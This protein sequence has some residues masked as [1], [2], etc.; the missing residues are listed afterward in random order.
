MASLLFINGRIFTAAG[1]DDGQPFQEAM[2]VVGDSIQHVGY[3]HDEVI[4]LAQS[5]GVKQ[6]DLD[7][8]IVAPGFIDSH[9]HIMDYSLSQHA[10]DLFPLKSLEEIRQSI[11]AY[12]HRNTQEPRIVCQGWI[13]SGSNDS[14]RAGL[15]DDLDPRPI[16]IGSKDMH[17][18]WC[19]TAALEELGAMKLPD[20]PGGKIHRDSDGKPTGLLSESAYLCLVWPFVVR[21]ASQ[22]AKVKAMENWAATYAAAGY[23]GVIDMAMG[24]DSWEALKVV[25]ERAGKMFPLHIAAHWLIPY[26]DDPSVVSREVDKVIAMRHEYHPS[27]SPDFCILGIKLLGD[28]VVDSCTAALNAPYTGMETLVNPIWPTD[29][30]RAVIQ[31]AD[32]AGLQ[33]AV[34]AIGDG[35]VTQALDAF[36]LA[37]PGARHRVEH[38]ELTSLEDAQRLGKLGITASVQPAHSD[39]V[40]FREWPQLI[41][42]DRC[43]RAFAYRDF[44][45][46][47]APMAFGTDAPTATHLPLHFLYSATTRRST[48]EPASR[49]MVN[50]QFAVSIASAVTAATRNAA[51]SRFAESWTGT[52]KPGMRAD[53]VVLDMD[54]KPQSLLQGKVC[55]TWAGGRKV[56]DMELKG[57]CAKSYD[58]R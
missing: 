23:T 35:A 24:E 57:D 3:R 37:T 44:L 50:S 32:A 39:P 27:K 8:K 10:L 47:G 49:E 28:G 15:L 45:E 55:Q 12:A 17:S 20:P 42:K 53:F 51:Y 58:V 7:N 40:T 19:N 38:L 43:G 13:Q 48:I 41:G 11:R 1:E 14:I 30:F 21:A 46:A 52:L 9:M 2:L 25:R 31:K 22:D 4:R 56:F 34:H 6:I 33:C 54:W 29:A 18:G 5:S 16:Y 26:S 36:S